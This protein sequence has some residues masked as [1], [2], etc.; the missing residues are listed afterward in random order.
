MTRHRRMTGRMRR[1][2]LLVL[3]G[4]VAMVGVLPA[5]PAFADSTLRVRGFSARSPQRASLKLRTLQSCNEKSLVLDRR[6]A[7]KRAR[8]QG[9]KQT[10]AQKVPA[11]HGSKLNKRKRSFSYVSKA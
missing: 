8:P 1:R 2:A 9:G 10:A 7:E 11:A 4:V 3:L 5:A 6:F